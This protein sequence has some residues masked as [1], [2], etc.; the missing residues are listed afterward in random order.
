[1]CLC[2][3]SEIFLEHKLETAYAC[4]IIANRVR[5]RCF[6]SCWLWA[7][8]LRNA[9]SKDD[10]YIDRNDKRFVRLLFYIFYWNLSIHLC[11]KK[12]TS[13]SPKKNVETCRSQRARKINFNSISGM[14]NTQP[15]SFPSLPRVLHTS[16]P[17][18]FIRDNIAAWFSYWHYR[19]STRNCGLRQNSALCDAYAPSLLRT[20]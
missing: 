1:M 9:M 11:V 18:N 8:E 17:Y 4:R 5:T 13:R 16:F 10:A 3:L 19:R 14:K 12:E 6:A 20:T 15:T 2:T 7:V